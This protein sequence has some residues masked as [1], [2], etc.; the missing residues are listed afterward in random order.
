MTE[1]YLERIT[2]FVWG[3]TDNINTGHFL[4]RENKILRF[5]PSL[6]RSWLAQH[7]DKGW[8]L[9]LLPASEVHQ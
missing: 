1:T 9:Y 6:H 2:T 7:Q 8:P 4:G 3:F 5:L